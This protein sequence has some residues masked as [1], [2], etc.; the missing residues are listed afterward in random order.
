M[1]RLNGKL[2]LDDGPSYQTKLI[3]RTKDEIPQTSKK[4]KKKN[5]T[6]PKQTYSV[7]FLLL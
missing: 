5:R 2:S 1:G 7:S 3:T 6:L 4:K